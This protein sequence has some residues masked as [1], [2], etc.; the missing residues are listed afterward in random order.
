MKAVLLALAFVALSS[1]TKRCVQPAPP[2]AQLPQYEQDLVGLVYEY[3]YGDWTVLLQ[4]KAAGQRLV[5]HLQRIEDGLDVL[6]NVRPEFFP[7]SSG[8]PTYLVLTSPLPWVWEPYQPAS[9]AQYAPLLLE[10]Y[11]YTGEGLFWPPEGMDNQAQT[12]PIHRFTFL[13]VE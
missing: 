10:C 3:D 8:V 4:F 5:A 9:S 12:N 7:F 2:V 13:Q 6:F 1:C 11:P